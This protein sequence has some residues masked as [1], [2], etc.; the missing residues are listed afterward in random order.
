MP[1]FKRG[2]PPNPNLQASKTGGEGSKSRGK[3]GV[4]IQNT[5]NEAR[6]TAKYQPPRGQSTKF[7]APYRVYG[8]A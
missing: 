6:E 4:F 2:K 7:E 1:T 8:D 5:D 3:H